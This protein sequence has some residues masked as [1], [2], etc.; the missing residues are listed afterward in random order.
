MARRWRT[1]G[2]AAYAGDAGNRT[3]F[4]SGSDH[5]DFFDA[6]PGLKEAMAGWLER[7]TR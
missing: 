2:A 1:T 5:N 7:V 3:V 4:E 6:S